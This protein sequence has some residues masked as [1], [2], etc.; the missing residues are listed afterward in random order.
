MSTIL[1][2]WADGKRLGRCD[3]NCYDAKGETCRCICRGR[4]HGAGR[5]LAHV[6]VRQHT[7]VILQDL[8]EQLGPTAE[9]ELRPFKWLSLHATVT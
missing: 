4:N 1:Q 3:A 9:I 5:H 8:A 2:A 6:H 7:A